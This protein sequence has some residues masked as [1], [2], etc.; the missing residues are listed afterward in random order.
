MKIID[1]FNDI[2]VTMVDLME[3]I[4]EWDEDIMREAN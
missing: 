2:G 4:F 3:N 1:N